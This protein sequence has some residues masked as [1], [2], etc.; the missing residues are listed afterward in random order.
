M[1]FRE[2]TLTECSCISV[3]LATLYCWMCQAARVKRHRKSEAGSGSGCNLSSW[4]CLVQSQNCLI[5]VCVSWAV[6]ENMQSISA[7]QH[8][9]SSDCFARADDS[10]QANLL[11][12]R[13]KM[14]SSVLRWD[15]WE[16]KGAVSGESTEKVCVLTA[17]LS[18][19]ENK[20][21]FHHR[22]HYSYPHM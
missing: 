9:S 12:W 16:A 15:T 18:T 1:C 11:I 13:E 22:T 2:I 4:F 20:S 3:K 8:V 5:L 21:S 17:V 14:V 6:E 19:L 10:S 7:S